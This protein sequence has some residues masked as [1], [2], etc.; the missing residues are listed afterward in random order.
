MESPKA[1]RI[2][3]PHR[4]HGDTRPDDYYW[5]RNRE[6]PDVIAYLE[7][8][9]A[10]YQEQMRPLG[11]LVDALFAEM[12]E[13]IPDVEEQV[14]VQDG[15]FF[16]YVRAE[17]S[18]QYPI[19]ARKRAASRAHLPEADEEIVLDVNELA[20]DGGYLSVTT[21]RVSP[22]G[23][24]LAYLVN[25]D[26]TDRCTLHVR[27]LSSGQELHDSI[28]NV[29]LHNS[30]EW[31]ATGRWLF[32]LTVDD[33]QRPFR[34]WRHEVGGD[35]DA[36]LYEE[37]DP[38]FSLDLDKSRSGRYLF[39]ISASKTTSEVRY[40][41]ADDPLAE[42][43]LFRTR[44]P[45]VEYTLEHWQDQ[46]L[47]LTNEEATNFRVLTCPVDRSTA[48]RDLFPYDERRYLTG[49]HPFQDALFL[50][51]REEG[52]TQ[53]WVYREGALRRLEWEEPIYTVRLG[54]NRSYH[55][56]EVLI[57]YQSLL[58]PRTTLALDTKALT[59]TV[60]QQAEVPGDY[61]PAAY[62]QER[63]WATAEDGTM[64]PLA[65]V[66]RRDARAAGPAP[67]ILNGYGSYGVNTDPHFRAT[68]LPLLDRGVMLA[69]AQVRG[70][71]EMG[72]QWYEDGKL[73]SKRNT[74]TDFAA[75]A[76]HLIEN[77]YTAPERLAAYGGS[78]GGLLMGAVANLEGSLFSAMA[79]LVP[80]VDV[81]T[82]ML[83]ETIPLTTLEWDEW[84]NPADKRYYEYMK[85]YSPYDNVEA[86][87][88]PHL[89]VTAGLNDPRVGYWEPAK[90]VARLRAMKTDDHV[91]VLKTHMGA[92]H[93]GSSG[94]LNQLRELAEMY[95]FL[96][97]KIGAGTA[98]NLGVQAGRRA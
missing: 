25:R 16:Y 34:L 46:F 96:L 10:Y 24:R 77:G 88:Y 6:N 4:L 30:V 85:S 90:W 37:A 17:K 28:P 8:E 11:P 5:L 36:M 49:L 70:G 43:T 23:R 98:S 93:F 18:K 21:L 87:P 48:P 64:V 42:W 53:V 40:L 44:A 62:H 32:Y 13:R 1:K 91:L 20:T 74:F 26:G 56:T 82:T 86:K 41:P 58:T 73:L 72:W 59:R 35:A 7:A 57:E 66:Y 95:A 47:I 52:L 15:E 54:A 97:D 60:L 61:D 80:F 29:F 78:A 19:Y 79:A 71:S 63:L 81:I 38:T 14:P 65:V 3:H 75:V 83:D 94:R 2:P 89:F 9:N 69:Y 50:S 31:D 92:G 68:L 45:G 27:D 33:T 22:D 76:R 84:G 67:L 39:L 55:T 51:G 12:T